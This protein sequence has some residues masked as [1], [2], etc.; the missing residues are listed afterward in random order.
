MDTAAAEK[1]L[2]MNES[3]TETVDGAEAPAGGTRL[4]NLLAVLRRRDRT[5][6]H[7]ALAATAG[8]APTVAATDNARM[9]AV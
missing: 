9:T 2:E 1:W 6:R 3:L 7:D 5:M 8:S 4:P